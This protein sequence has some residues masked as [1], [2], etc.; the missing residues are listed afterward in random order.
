MVL[1]LAPL[2]PQSSPEGP[3]HSSRKTRASPKRDKLSRHMQPGGVVTPG[4]SVGFTPGMLDGG[5]FL[6]YL[7]K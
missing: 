4:R 6:L 2:E 1:S 7:V 5:G 3:A